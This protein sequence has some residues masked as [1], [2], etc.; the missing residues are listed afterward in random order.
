[1]K[2][3]KPENDK[4]LIIVIFYGEK[5]NTVNAPNRKGAK[6]ITKNLLFK[7]VFN[8]ISY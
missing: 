3:N 8:L 4:K 6:K 1:M 5:H 7:I 2:N